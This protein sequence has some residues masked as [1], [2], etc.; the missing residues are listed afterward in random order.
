MVFKKKKEMIKLNTY[1]NII[2]SFV[3]R[4]VNDGYSKDRILRIKGQ[5]RKLSNYLV[6]NSIDTLC[7]KF[8][9]YLPKVLLSLLVVMPFIPFFIIIY[10]KRHW[11]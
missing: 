9:L 6:D 1:N 5:M 11:G 10:I 2:L 3:E 8:R 7:E 4:M